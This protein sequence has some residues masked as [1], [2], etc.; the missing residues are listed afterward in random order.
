MTRQELM[1]KYNAVCL[2][3]LALSSLLP[4]LT[5]YELY[6][7]IAG[8][9]VD[10]GQSIEKALKNAKVHMENRANAER[11]FGKVNLH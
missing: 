4:D 5:N 6:V 2:K 9:T 1:K 7:W 8:K 11:V 10:Y 3:H